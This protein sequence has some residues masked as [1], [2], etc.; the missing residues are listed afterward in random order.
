MPVPARRLVSGTIWVDTVPG[1]EPGGAV[2]YARVSSHD[3]R[4]DLYRHAADGSADPK[5]KAA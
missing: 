3:Q 2:L 5:G 4:A 1:P